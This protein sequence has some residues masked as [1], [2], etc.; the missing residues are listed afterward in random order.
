MEQ[1]LDLELL[2]TFVMVSRTGELK[3]AAQKVHRSQG[4]VSMQMKRLEELTGNLLM[5]RGNRGIRLTDAG[6]T[7]LRYSEEMISLNSAAL[8]AL[9]GKDVSGQLSFGIPT[10]YAQNFLRFFMPVLAN[11]LPNLDAKIVCAR[12]RSLR[13]Q[14][15]EGKLDV[16]IVADEPSVSD[17]EL[18]W[19]E[20][21]VWSAP[22][23]ANLEQQTV[24]PVAVYEDNCIVRDLLL[25]ALRKASIPYRIVFSSPILENI[26]TAVEEGFAI[27]LLPESLLSA[28]NVRQLPSGVLGSDQLLKINMI[29][30]PEI[31]TST[32]MRVSDCFRQASDK[33]QQ[34]SVTR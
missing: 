10:D 20:R 34:Q 21:L 24:L 27:S 31:E 25:E 8:S 23:C 33:Q 22:V 4:A 12:S 14:I 11:E 2:R 29:H 19:S 18:L 16:A 30:R 15:A 5:E 13:Q 26:A 6:E 28:H 1:M 9:G 17:E 7:L 32:L 3:K